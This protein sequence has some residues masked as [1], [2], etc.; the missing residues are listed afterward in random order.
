MNNKSTPIGI[1]FLVNPGLRIVLV[2]L[3]WIAGAVMTMFVSVLLGRIFN[4][5]SLSF[6]RLTTV[7][8]DILM[9]IVP[10]LITAMIVT[11]QPA[12]LLAVDSLP[13]GRQTVIAILLLIVSTPLMSWIIN[14]NA[15]FHLPESMASLEAVLR[16]MEENAEQVVRQMLDPDTPGSLIVNLLIIGVFAGFSEELFFRGTL[17][18][19]LATSNLSPHIAIWITAV[20]FS[21]LH[22]QFFGFVPRMLLGA[23]FGYLL[24]WSGSVWLPMLIHALNNSVFVILYTVTGSGDPDLGSESSSCV[25]ICISATLTGLCLWMLYRSRTASL[26]DSAEKE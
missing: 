9:L 6:L 10:A 3:T 19:V 15:N 16:V 1:R 4:G 11:R 17:Q 13:T 7:F 14:V 25:A 23:I 5:E 24:W 2:F 8:Q 26:V 22:F 18:R 21:A 12:R 20:I